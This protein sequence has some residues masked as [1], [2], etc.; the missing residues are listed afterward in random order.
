MREITVKIPL[1]PMDR[2]SLAAQQLAAPIRHLVVGPARFPPFWACAT[3]GIRWSTGAH[4]DRHAVR[5][6]EAEAEPPSPWW[7]GEQSSRVCA[8]PSGCAH[9]PRR[10]GRKHPQGGGGDAA[11]LHAQ[12]DALTSEIVGVMRRESPG[13]YSERL[14]LLAQHPRFAPASC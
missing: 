4:P 14:L 6:L 2:A 3:C 9:D 13:Q 11:E 5:L 10:C 12:V 8:E 1:A 7:D